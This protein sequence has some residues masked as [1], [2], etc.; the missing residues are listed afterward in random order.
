MIPAALL[1]GVGLG[2]ALVGAAWLLTLW[3]LRH[4]A[5]TQRVL[6]NVVDEAAGLRGFLTRV[7]GDWLVL[8]QVEVCPPNDTPTRV[9][10]A[11]VLERRR[12]L[13]IQ[14]LPGGRTP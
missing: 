6:V 12:V 10:G 7:R 5:L 9:D 1:S 2:A 14:I 13:F 3:R 8:E 4:P 11:L